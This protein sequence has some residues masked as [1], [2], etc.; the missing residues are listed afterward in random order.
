MKKIEAFLEL[1]SLKR[2]FIKAFKPENMKTHN[3]KNFTRKRS[4]MFDRLF[5]M[6]L[7]CSPNSLQIRLDDYFKVYMLFPNDHALLI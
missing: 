7:R 5:A 3:G 6:I 4:L 1:I 2:A